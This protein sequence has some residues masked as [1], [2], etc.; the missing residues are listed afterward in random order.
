VKSYL[1]NLFAKLVTDPD[2]SIPLVRRLFGE[3][4]RAQLPNYIWAVVCMG[5]GAGATAG[6]ALFMRHVVDTVFLTQHL[7]MMWMLSVGIV[8]LS[9]CK[10]AAAYGQA[11]ALSR[12]GNSITAA[13]QRR[14]FDKVLSLGVDYFS[15]R[16]SSQVVIRVTQ[17]ARAAREVV[18]IVSL[19]LGRDL[20]TVIG[21]AGVMIYL[22]PIMSILALT[23]VPPILFGVTGISRR[24]RELSSGEFKS[25]AGIA[26]AAQETIAG[27][28]IVKSFTLEAPMRARLEDAVV[29]A[30]RRANAL[31]RIQ[32][33]RAPI[34]ESLRGIAIGLV[35]TYAA[36]QM[37]GRGQTPGEFVAF[38]TAFM[39]AYEPAKKLFAVNMTLQR[40][41]QGVRMMYE[42]LD[43][44]ERELE[45]PDAIELGRVKGSIA[46][47]DVTFGYNK[48][49]PVLQGVSIEAD[50]GSIVAL[51]GPSGTGKTTIVGLI[52]RFYDPGSGTITI[53]GVDIRNVT[54]ASLR[55]QISF[56][57]Q[58]T[59]LF[60]G[61]VRENIGFGYPGASEADIMAAVEAANAADFIAKLPKQLD[62]AIGENGATLSG[63]QRQR[64][65]IARAILKNAP[66][67]ILDEA[68]SALDTV[69]ERQVQAALERLMKG[70]TTIV[71]AH[72]LSTVIRA[73]RT[74]AIE[75]G[76]V[77]ESGSHS[78]LIAR[79]RL[80]AQ[81]FGTNN[82]GIA[83]GKL[84]KEWQIAK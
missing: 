45:L 65:A 62:T 25:L 7:T 9:A 2:S 71:I 26:A 40:S 52:Q 41:L 53:D 50:P 35:T 79:N 11:I 10:G 55:R 1:H 51:V 19:S 13:M 80:Y 21:L 6:L 8:A 20:F 34:M 64:I 32:A 83:D 76:K 31:V 22:D 58:D 15:R 43:L 54:I 70:R 57:S 24:M 37:V 4:F 14:L 42:F 63:G 3:V 60:S 66:I 27:I 82:D 18:S 38:L 74:Y 56:V 33:S 29:T 69:S 23:I 81:L 5:L 46:L 17:N 59:F 44:P 67:L 84:A 77:V 72:R 28:R 30:E 61:T 47:A 49:K 36:W 73:D 39:L 75:A 78:S 12:I 68:T 16:H 48:D